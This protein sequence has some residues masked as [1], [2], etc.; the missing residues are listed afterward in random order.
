VQRGLVQLANL[1]NDDFQVDPRFTL[2]QH[3]HRRLD[4]VVNDST[5]K[6]LYGPIGTPPMPNPSETPNK[7][8]NPSGNNTGDRNPLSLHNLVHSV[9]DKQLA[10]A[11]RANA[12]DR[13]IKKHDNTIDLQNKVI[14]GMRNQHAKLEAEM[15]NKEVKLQNKQAALEKEIEILKKLV[16]KGSDSSTKQGGDEE[17]EK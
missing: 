1:A 7:G 4:R 5:L 14:A 17:E 10:D 2:E 16:L 11:H 6:F 13:E 3:Y 12:M 15:K 8:T 9:F